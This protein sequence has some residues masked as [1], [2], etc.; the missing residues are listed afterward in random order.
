MAIKHTI[1][2]DGCGKVSPDAE[3]KHIANHWLTCDIKGRLRTETAS[4]H[5]CTDCIPQSPDNFIPPL[6]WIIKLIRNY[7]S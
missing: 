3:G 2:C 1:K 7:F 5:F 6:S 4:L